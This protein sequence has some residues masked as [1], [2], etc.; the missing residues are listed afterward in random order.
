M[1]ILHLIDSAGIYGAEKVL[2]SLARECIQH[3]DDVVVGTI[4]APDDH[5]DPLGE[6]SEAMGIAHVRFTMADGFDTGG[7]RELVRYAD[8][9]GF[10]VVHTHGYKANILIAISPLASRRWA[11][12]CTLHGWTSQSR[13]SRLFIY[14]AIERRV[15]RRA[16]R[17]IAVSDRIAQRIN[18]PT[19]IG[20]LVTI[21]NGIRFDVAQATNQCEPESGASG[22]ATR[23]LAI[24]RLSREKG[25]DLLM[26]A[27]HLLR[28]RGFAVRL[29][30]AGDGAERANLEGLVKARS[31]ETEVTFLGYETDAERLF[32]DADVFVL[33]SRTEGLPLVL[34]EAMRGGV[35][36][37]STPVGDVP[38]VLS[39]TRCGWMSDDVS[40]EALA[41]AMAQALRASPVERRR[42]A[43]AARRMVEERYSSVVMTDRYRAIYA[44]V[45][46]E[47]SPRSIATAS[48]AR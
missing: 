16:D 14:E 18:R 3:G 11:H 31:L 37:V 10:N 24:G 33:S 29:S 43:E 26:D 32:R 23:L 27:M 13:L 19:I 35:S 22:S 34:L 7:L 9:G 46:A 44:Q 38:E 21:P 45:V 1:R 48:E 5:R 28:E 8:Q 40:A 2:L 41:D 4:V 15:L 36:V 6:A 25:F 47:R 39:G 17:I 42:R 30:L 20:R 12:V